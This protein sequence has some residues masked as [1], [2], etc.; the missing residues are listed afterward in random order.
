MSNRDQGMIGWGSTCVI[1]DRDT[2]LNCQAHNLGTDW[3]RDQPRL[4][5]SGIEIEQDQGK[6]AEPNNGKAR[7]PRL[8]ENHCRN[9]GTYQEEAGISYR[10]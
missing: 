5:P 1:P 2:K 3:D 10:I 6:P 4:I 7:Y 8:G 9:I